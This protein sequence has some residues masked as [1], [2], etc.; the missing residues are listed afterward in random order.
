MTLP[1]V[2]FGGGARIRRPSSQSEIDPIDREHRMG[3]EDPD[4]D[5]AEQQLPLTDL[6]EDAEELPEPGQLPVEADPA[7]G[8]V[9]LTTKMI[10][11]VLR[12]TS[13]SGCQPGFATTPC[14][15]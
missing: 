4:L 2:R 5:V 13:R 15:S 3:I 6:D 1:A 12:T 9:N 14:V 8:T 11:T 10:K 7:D